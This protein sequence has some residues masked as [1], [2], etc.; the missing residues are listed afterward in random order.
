M[1]YEL[2]ITRESGQRELKFK[3]DD[4]VKR[5]CKCQITAI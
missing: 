2:I 5:C 1:Y 4:S 3:N